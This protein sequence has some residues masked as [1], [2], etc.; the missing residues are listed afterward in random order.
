MQV[1]FSGG[2]AEST[3]FKDHEPII[4]VYAI[5]DGSGEN[6]LY[7]SPMNAPFLG[8]AF[9]EEDYRFR[10]D[11]GALCLDLVATVGRRGARPY[12]RLRTV[13]DFARWCVETGLFVVPPAVTEADLDA[14]RTAREAVYRSVE[15]GRAGRSLAIDDLRLINEWAMRPPLAPQ[16]VASG[17]A[18]LWLAGHPVQAVLS[19]IAR[20]AIDVLSGRRIRRVRRCAKPPCSILFIDMSRPGRRRWC[21]MR[22]CGNEAKKTAYRSRMAR[23]AATR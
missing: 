12:D 6:L 15:A 14:A 10:F 17:A 23:T 16:L 19:T 7:Y 22:R 11:S 4:P 3:A 2:Q 20:D 21:S 8:K 18:R 1:E 5:L 13:D 9:F